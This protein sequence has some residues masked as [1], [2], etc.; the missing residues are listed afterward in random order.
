MK[1]TLSAAPML[2]W[3][4]SHA[5]HCTT[6]HMLNSEIFKPMN[7]LLNWKSLFEATPSPEMPFLIPLVVIFSAMII[8]AAALLIFA[9]SERVAIIR[10]YAPPMYTMGALG[11]IHLFARYESLPGIASRFTLLLLAVTFLI[12]FCTV[13]IIV[14]RTMPKLAH[15]RATEEKFQK[16][17]PK[18]KIKV[19][20]LESS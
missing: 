13:M 10:K 8:G 6:E 12:W 17:L 19:R 1:A 3:G 14:F 11:F 5:K 9:R 16:Y 7:N 15:E 4:K 20:K 2:K 18:R